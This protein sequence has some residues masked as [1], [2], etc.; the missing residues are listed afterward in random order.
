[1][2]EYL[3]YVLA[4]ILVGGALV[5]AVLVDETSCD[6]AVNMGVSQ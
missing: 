1:M 4:L 6:A 2:K 3:A 5:Y